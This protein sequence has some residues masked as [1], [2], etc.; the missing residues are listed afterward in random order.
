M[1]APL[2]IIKQIKANWLYPDKIGNNSHLVGNSI[3]SK[4]KLTA[5]LRRILTSLTTRVNLNSPII[6][7]DFFQ[8]I[9]S[10]IR[11]KIRC[12]AHRAR[13]TLKI[14]TSLKIRE[15]EERSAECNSPVI[16]WDR[17][18]AKEV[19]IQ[20]LPQFSR[21]ILLVNRSRPTRIINCN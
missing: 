14:R 11:L 15:T 19:W 17:N 7:A 12:T 6:T 5:I 18:R 13:I 9:A 10:I 3:I 16:K 21:D 1:E 4:D 2:Q 8:E 20:F